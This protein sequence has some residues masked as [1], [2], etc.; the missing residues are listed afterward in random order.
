MNCDINWIGSNEDRFLPGLRLGP[1]GSIIFTIAGTDEIL[2]EYFPI[3]YR[4]NGM[5]RRDFPNL[6]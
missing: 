3:D 5:A 2:D 6:L 4:F 1:I